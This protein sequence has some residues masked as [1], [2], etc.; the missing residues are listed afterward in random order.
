M[1]KEELVQAAAKKAN[2]TQKEVAEVLTALLESIEEAV[3]AGDR[4][5]L[6][7]FGTF[8][9]RERQARDGRN[10]Q[11]GELIKIPA[12]RIPAFTAGKKF[13][14]RV[15]PVAKAAEPKKKAAKK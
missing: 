1:N 10:P 15:A 9:A 14:D 7:G 11:N 6:V 5:T 8:E 4:V 2:T 3:A 13:K 12:K